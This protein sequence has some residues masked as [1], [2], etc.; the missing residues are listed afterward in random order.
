M[1]G[2]LRSYL[3]D[4][5]LGR[6]GRFAYAMFILLL[7]VYFGISSEVDYLVPLMAVP[8]GHIV[9]LG[10]GTRMDRYWRVM[11][12]KPSRIMLMRYFLHLFMLLFGVVVAVTGILV[13]S[14]E[15]I[16]KLNFML[17]L[18]GMTL[19]HQGVMNAFVNNKPNDGFMSLLITLV[20]LIGSFLQL[21]LVFGFSTINSIITG[22]MS[23]IPIS[24]SGIFT[25]TT[26]WIVFAAVNIIIYIV[27]YFVAVYLYKR[28][29]YQQASAW[30]V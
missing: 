16:T 20:L 9:F 12:I 14:D 5:T 26:R 28:R 25:E 11:P 18:L 17:L 1:A 4:T 30:W 6:L 7:I 8:M 10:L 22:R 19:S 23:G 13:F 3:V 27:S 15:I 2:I 24:D 21:Y 29:D